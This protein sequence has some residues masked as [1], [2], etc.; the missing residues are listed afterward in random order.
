[1]DTIYCRP[2]VGIAFF[3]NRLHEMASKSY[4]KHNQV[5]DA[6][7]QPARLFDEPCFIRLI[8]GA[9]YEIIKEQ[10]VEHYSTCETTAPL[11]VLGI[12]LDLFP[13]PL[14]IDVMKVGAGASMRLYK[15]YRRKA[16]ALLK[17]TIKETV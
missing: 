10:I 12:D 3:N 9:I 15:K 1:M 6:S 14:I 8:D 5:L 2:S 16:K 13:H 4:R 7:K 17:T 11:F